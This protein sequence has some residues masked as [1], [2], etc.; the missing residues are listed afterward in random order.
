MADYIKATNFAAK[1]ALPMGNSAK[2]ILGTEIDAELTAIQAAVNSK[3][4]EASPT[5]TGTANFAAITASGAISGL[6]LSLTEQVS[7]NATRLSTAGAQTT[8]ATALFPTIR[9]NIGLGYNAG[10]GIFT[11]PA[12]GLYVFSATCTIANNAG[13]V[14]NN[15]GISFVVD[16]LNDGRAR[17]SQPT[18]PASGTCSLCISE[19]MP[20]T[21]G[22]TVWV[23]TP[24][25]SALTAHNVG[26]FS[27]ARLF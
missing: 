2:R 6:N 16:G 23:G 13:V 22:Q 19:I 17:N 24:V 9:T 14:L 4:D 15:A 26:T 3:A 12:T 11:A 21:A 5:F 8:G 10:T 27:G 18:T 1:D 20:L 25:L 7:F